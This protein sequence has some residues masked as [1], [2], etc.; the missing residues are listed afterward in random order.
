[1]NGWDTIKEV[2]LE[3]SEASKLAKTGSKSTAS[4]CMAHAFKIIG[5]YVATER[6]PEHGFEGSNRK[7]QR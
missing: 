3:L 4:A 7:G 2:R 1:M 5:M 6:G